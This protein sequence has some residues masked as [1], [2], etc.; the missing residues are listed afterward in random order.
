MDRIQGDLRP[1]YTPPSG[2]PP[3]P[4]TPSKGI[5]LTESIVQ[6]ALDKEGPLRE[7]SIPRR[8]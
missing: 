6:A 3:P 4:A 1:S 8:F 7:K 5:S 2:E